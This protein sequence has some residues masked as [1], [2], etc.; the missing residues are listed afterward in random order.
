MCALENT[1]QFYNPNIYGD[2]LSAVFDPDTNMQPQS[3]TIR[4]I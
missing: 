2:V 3:R 4:Q 1:K